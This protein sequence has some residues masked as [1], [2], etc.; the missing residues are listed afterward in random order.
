[1]TGTLPYID[2]F[3]KSCLK[4][5]FVV[6]FLRAAVVVGSIA[7]VVMFVFVQLKG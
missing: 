3:K 2:L 6:L 5:A 4:K 1:M 7:V